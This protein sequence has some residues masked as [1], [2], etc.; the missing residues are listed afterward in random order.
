MNGYRT[1]YFGTSFDISGIV[2]SCTVVV[3]VTNKNK[4]LHK[5]N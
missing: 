5:K 3:N 4:Y 2:K 1:W